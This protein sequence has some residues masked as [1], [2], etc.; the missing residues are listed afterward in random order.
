[1]L[2]ARFSF[3]TEKPTRDE[4]VKMTAISSQVFLFISQS[5]STYQ[6]AL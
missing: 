4:Y 1:M 5:V 6:E 2:H 3:W